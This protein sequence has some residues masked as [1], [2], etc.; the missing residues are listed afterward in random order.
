ESAEHHFLTNLDTIKQH[1]Q[2][3]MVFYCGLSRLL[4][5]EDVLS[6]LAAIPGKLAAARARAEQVLGVILREFSVFE[7]GY[8][9]LF[10][11]TDIVL[12]V[13]AG[14]KQARVFHDLCEKVQAG[15]P[16]GCCDAGMM[17]TEIYRY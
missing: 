7:K 8:A 3:W 9:Y 13:P 16:R 10:A 4:S 5:H 11:D 2:G 17:A 12:L 15:L 1:P 14:V 6:D